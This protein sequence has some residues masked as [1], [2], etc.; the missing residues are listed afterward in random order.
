MT[1][2]PIIN[3][4][5]DGVIY[6][7]VPVAMRW[8]GNERSRDFG[9]VMR[10]LEGASK[11]HTAE[12][13]WEFWKL[14]DIDG[15][16]FWDFVEENAGTE[17]PYPNIYSIGEP[18][19]GAMSSL[20]LLSEM[21][22]IRIVTR[23]P[24]KQQVR[25]KARMAM[26]EYLNG[27]VPVGAIVLASDSHP[28]SQWSD[29][30]AVVD[31]NPDIDEWRIPGALNLLFNSPWNQNLALYQDVIR[32]NSWDEIV[33]LM[34]QHSFKVLPPSGKQFQP[35]IID[36][37]REQALEAISLVY[38]ARAESYGHPYDDFKRTAETF[39]AL[40]GHNLTPVDAALMMLC[41]KLSRE[42]NKHKRANIVDAHGYLMVMERIREKESE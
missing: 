39:N 7:F 3:V 30:V 32:V 19:Y 15:K 28:K 18:I 33:S 16:D 42:R 11:T 5:Y 17:S 37:A 2:K 6:P 34:M 38:G 29:A 4:D 10:L 31:D 27:R 20:N 22:S 1:S 8:Y 24:H 21:Y 9:D 23:K 25:Q 36:A 26:Y 13:V 40:T 12:E 41:V 35:A 14:F